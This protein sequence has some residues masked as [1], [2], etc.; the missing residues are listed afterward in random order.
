MSEL[1]GLKYQV[2]LLTT[3]EAVE[4]QERSLNLLRKVPSLSNVCILNSVRDVEDT[5]R[6]TSG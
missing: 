2:Y 3:Q 1:A 6:G 5:R 4:R